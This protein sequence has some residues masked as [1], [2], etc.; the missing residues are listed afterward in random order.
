VLPA[1]LR[2]DY[3]EQPEPLGQ[4]DAVLRSA[5][6]LPAEFLLVQP[7]NINAGTIAAE[8]AAEP[9][10]GQAV[11]LAV[12]PRR[13]WQLYAVVEHDG[14][15][16]KAIVEKPATA[17][18][19]TPLCNMGV[20]RLRD[21]FLDYLRAVPADPY[22]I[23]TAIE[24]AAGDRRARIT[25]SAATFLP[26]KYPGHLWG[27]V[28]E[29]HGGTVPDTDSGRLVVGPGGTLGAGARLDN[30][31]LGPDV[32]VGPGAYTDPVETWDDLDAVVIGPAAVLGADVRLGRG[33]KIGAGAL[34]RDGAVV[35]ADVPD[36]AAVS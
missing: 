25:Q 8:F 6:L 31:I 15:V 11:T 27:H 18:E 33:V 5:H 3:V 19:P 21:D 36:G 12:T 13:D 32:T 23:I 16:L 22:A 26:L 28:R 2:I 14:P 17:P 10:A 30:A 29:L 7:E 34:V 1:T 9:D 4:G 24:R 20:Y 35:D